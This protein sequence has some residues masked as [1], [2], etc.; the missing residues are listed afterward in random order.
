MSMLLHNGCAGR[1]LKSVAVRSM[2][3]SWWKH[4]EPAPKD[5]ILGVTETFL[6]D[7]SPDKVNVGVGTYRDDNEM[8][9]VLECVREAERRITAAALF[10]EKRDHFRF[11]DVDWQYMDDVDTPPPAIKRHH[12]FESMKPPFGPPDDYTTVS[13]PPVDLTLFLK[14]SSKCYDYHHFMHLLN[15]AAVDRTIAA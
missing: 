1:I 10:V 7:P 8:P 4:V 15:S 12:P 2:S 3:T 14:S 11:L 6:A 13:L 9:V 5:P